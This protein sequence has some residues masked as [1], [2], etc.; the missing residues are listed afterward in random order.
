MI[1]SKELSFMKESAFIV[2]TA[3]GGIID[4]QA[5]SDSLDSGLIKGAAMDVFDKEP[6][7][8]SPLLKLPNFIATPHMAGYTEEALREVGMLTA[9][10]VIDVLEAR[11]PAYTVT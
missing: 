11:K 2:N 9:Q 7:S 1:G 10:N 3:R 5:L 4:E 8:N 6:L